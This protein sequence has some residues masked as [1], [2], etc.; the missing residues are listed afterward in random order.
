MSKP[1]LFLD[2]DG[3][4]FRWQLF[5]EW[6][7]EMVELGVLP[8]AVLT[9][10]EE[11]LLAYRDRKGPFKKFV[12]ELVSSYQDEGRLSGVHVK[13]AILAAREVIK[14]KGERIHV[15]PRELIRAAKEE[16]YLTAVISGSPIEVIRE[17]ANK[18]GLDAAIGTVHPTDNGR[19][20]G[21]KP[22]VWVLDKSRAVEKIC[23]E[24]DIDL[25]NSIAMGDS[26]NDVPMLNS[27]GYK[28]CFNPNEELF[29]HAKHERLPV[30]VERKLIFCFDWNGE[31]SYVQ[32]DPG[33]VDWFLP[34]S[35]GRKLK[36]RLRRL[37]V[38]AF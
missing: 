31:G 32:A 15:F 20:T 21:G 38:A 28:I 4:I 26:E 7:V 11:S 27:V 5:H 12:N 30:V 36:K 14:K 9:K 22:E 1:C 24:H 35:M 33:T 18:L 25:E 10:T 6:I 3:T 37:H 19:F 34:R 23:Q 13:D 2:A 16:N 8:Q 17:F 29:R